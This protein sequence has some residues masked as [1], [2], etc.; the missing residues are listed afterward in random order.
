MVLGVKV[1][2]DREVAVIGKKKRESKDTWLEV[3]SC[4]WATAR[5]SALL[6]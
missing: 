2:C 3:A 6:R 1:R 5:T 4:L